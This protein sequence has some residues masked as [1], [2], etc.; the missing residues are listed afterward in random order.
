MEDRTVQLLRSIRK[1][2]VVVLVMLQLDRP[3]GE[4]E[5]AE[6]LDINQETARRYLKSLCRVGLATRTGR[7]QGY[8]LTGLGSQLVLPMET[9]V[10]ERG[11]SALERGKTALDAPITTTVKDSINKSESEVVESESANAENPRS[12]STGAVD[13][14]VWKE[15]KAAGIGHNKRTE[16]LA[17]MEH[18]TPQ[19][20]KAWAAQMRQ[21]NK[22]DQTGLLITILEGGQEAPPTYPNGHL[23]TCGCPECVRY[24]YGVYDDEED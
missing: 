21:D 24:K 20:V 7:F 5:I 11:K 17:K 23:Q 10:L 6:I 9:P 2:A 22:A 1:T 16:K 15:L 3:T 8:T 14:P 19:Y 13:N 4:V 18:V 12:L